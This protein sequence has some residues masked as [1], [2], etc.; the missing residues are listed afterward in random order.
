MTRLLLCVS[1]IIAVALSLADDANA[2]PAQSARTAVTY[3]CSASSHGEC[4]YI[5]YRSDCKDGPA[6]N[7]HPSLVCTHTVVA[8]FSLKAGESK[9]FRDLPPNTT[10]CNPHEGRSAFRDCIR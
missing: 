4:K 10:V 6:N 7:G 9:S 8:Q 3:Y 2:Q 5:L 1:F